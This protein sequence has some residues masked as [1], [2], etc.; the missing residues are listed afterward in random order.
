MPNGNILT[1][2]VTLDNQPIEKAKV[3]IKTGKISLI[4]G[5]TGADGLYT[6]DDVVAGTLYE[7]S[8][9]AL[10]DTRSTRLNWQPNNTVA[11][12]DFPRTGG[13]I[14]LL[15]NT[16]KSI[17]HATSGD[18]VN[19]DTHFGTLKHVWLTPGI[20]PGSNANEATWDTSGSSG[21]QTLKV[22]VSDPAD[23]SS[24]TLTQAVY[25]APQPSQRVQLYF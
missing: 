3:Q 14:E 15:D 20:T 9:T 23:G 25:L 10:S 4:D 7:I 12:I 6:V 13:K 24:V 5:V 8:V 17:I 2:K 16:G 18:I 1:V 21:Q 11:K 19:L 22:S